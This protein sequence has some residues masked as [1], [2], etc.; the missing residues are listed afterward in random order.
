MKRK[1][2]QVGTMVFIGLLAGLVIGLFLLFAPVAFAS[3]GS[4]FDWTSLTWADFLGWV[5]T[6]SGVSVLAG[7]VLSRV[8]EIYWA[9]Y[10]S[11]TKE[12]KT[13]IFFGLCLLIPI[14]GA[15]LGVFSLGWP[16]T[17]AET[18]W[19]AVM[20][21]V[22]AGGTGTIAHAILPRRKK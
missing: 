20:A 16:Y 5:V 1:Y 9:A 8:I 17:W 22:F 3:D 15:A 2:G 13:I 18:W 21:G 12:R 11:Y 14:A 10:H 7:V 19:P 4:D 6:P